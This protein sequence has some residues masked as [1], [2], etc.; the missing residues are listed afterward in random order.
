LLI[1]AKEQKATV[2]VIVR[3]A[4][5]LEPRAALGVRQW[6]RY[7]GFLRI[8]LS[9][10]DAANA[11][12]VEAMNHR[13]EL[14]RQGVAQ[15]FP[16]TPEE[17]SQLDRERSLEA[18]VELDS[19]SFYIFAKILLDRVADTFREYFGVRLGGRG[20]S[21]AALTAAFTKFCRRHAIAPRGLDGLIETLR[22]EIVDY[23]TKVIEHA[24]E[25][26]EGILMWG[27]DDRVK[28]GIRPL[29]SRPEDGPSRHTID[30]H[31]L[32]AILE[33]Y[34]ALM[35]QFMKLHADK[36]VLSPRQDRR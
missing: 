2:D 4:L 12:Y 36:S 23:R 22:A 1:T 11:P 33:E 10:Y 29:S 35:L 5:E 20:S 3:F 7:L 26:G 18:R 6:A 32:L 8:I 13:L 14:R 31:A 25:T 21:H 30:P 28:L 17:F 16:T 9:R 34:I 24:S 27:G 15:H 19:E